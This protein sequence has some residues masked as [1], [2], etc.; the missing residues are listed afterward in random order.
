MFSPQEIERIRL[1]LV[2]GQMEDKWFIYWQDDALYF[3]RSWTGICVYV[4]RFEIDGDSYRMCEADLNREPSQYSQTNDDHDAA[5]IS[6]L[7][8]VLLLEREA[9][10]P[11]EAADEGKAALEQWSSVGRAMLDEPREQSLEEFRWAYENGH[12][13]FGPTVVA[14]GELYEQVASS[15]TATQM[16]SETSL[17][18]S[19]GQSVILSEED[20]QHASL[21]LSALLRGAGLE[22]SEVL[23]L[24]HKDNRAAKGRSPYELWRDDRRQFQSY[25]SVQRV[26]YQKMFGRPYWA[27]FVVN[28]FEEEVFAGIW[29]SA[30]QY[31][32]KEARPG[33]S[34]PQIIDAPETCDQY[35]TILTQRL[36]ELIGKLIID[37]GRGK[38]AWAQYADKNEKRV[39]EI[40]QNEDDPFPGFTNFREPL[41]RIPRLP[42]TWIS[43]LANCK[44]V[45]LLSSP[46]TNQQYV[47]SASG[48]S[49]FFG[50]WSDYAASGH[51]GNV[52]LKDKETRDWQVTILQVAGSADTE[53]DILAY[54]GLWQTKLQSHRLGLNSSLA[55][56]PA[57]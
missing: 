18:I 9:E 42:Q 14:T 35:D 8:D 45:Y 46:K 57:A 56:T 50:R 30:R 16:D 22:P 11:S 36:S 53:S 20:T 25:Q 10:F 33:I 13:E 44:G 3:H 41:W 38:I 23:L 43:A 2:P 34:N 1:G 4:V 31:T 47:G 24:R 17:P 49:G 28:A 29:K 51:G 37:W 26:K 54:E 39:L 5:M 32:I 55:S 52:Q 7:I 12:V 48:E 21:S 6:Y 15:N 27:A 19:S 40:R